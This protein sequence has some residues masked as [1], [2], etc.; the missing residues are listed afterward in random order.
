MYAIRSYY[1][2]IH[3]AFTTYNPLPAVGSEDSTTISH[4]IM[5]SFNPHVIVI[6]SYSIHYTKLYDR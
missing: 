4:S 5:E 3:Q 1:A 6:T 2:D